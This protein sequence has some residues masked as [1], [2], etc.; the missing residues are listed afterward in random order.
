MLL[1]ASNSDSEKLHVNHAIVKPGRSLPG[2]THRPPYDET[3]N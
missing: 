1:D 2:A 3:W